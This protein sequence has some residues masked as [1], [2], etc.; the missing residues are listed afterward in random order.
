MVL[1]GFLDLGTSCFRFY[2]FFFFFLFFLFLLSS[3]PAKI[4]QLRYNISKSVHVKIWTLKFPFMTRL[5]TYFN[6]NLFYLQNLCGGYFTI[7]FSCK[8]H[9]MLWKKILTKRYRLHY[10]KN[11]ARK[12]S[13]MTNIVS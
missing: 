1:G 11:H 13:V 12:D 2:S 10:L 5:L 3:P 9:H 7:G 6:G 4:N 8:R